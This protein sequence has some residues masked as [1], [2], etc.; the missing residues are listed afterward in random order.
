MNLYNRLMYHLILN[1]ELGH[2]NCINR[3]IKEKYKNKVVIKP[4]KIV[5]GKLK[6]CK[7]KKC[8]KKIGEYLVYCYS[9]EIKGGMTLTPHFKDFTDEEI[10][11]VAKAGFNRELITGSIFFIIGVMGIINCYIAHI[12]DIFNVYLKFTIL[13]I[14]AFII[15]YGAIIIFCGVYNYNHSDS[16]GISTDKYYFNDPSSFKEVMQ[17]NISKYSIHLL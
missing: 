5:I 17:S 16:S 10:K 2:A 3:I 9:K 14:F 11:R 12:N 8:S 6:D 1:H 4:T 13:I 15:M 7:G